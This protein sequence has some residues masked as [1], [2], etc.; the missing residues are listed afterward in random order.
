MLKATTPASRRMM[1]ASSSTPRGRADKASSPRFEFQMLLRCA[2]RPAARA[3]ASG[4]Q[5]RVYVRSAPSGIPTHAPA[6]PSGRPRG[7][8]VR[9][10]GAGVPTAELTDGTLAATSGCTSARPRSPGA[11]ANRTPWDVRRRCPDAEG[12]TVRRC[13]SCAGLTRV[14]VRRTPRDGLPLPGHTRRRPCPLLALTCRTS[15]SSSTRVSRAGKRRG[16]RGRV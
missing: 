8:L 15:S 10:H 11:T 13:C 6:P 9:Q 2:R 7:V 14:I 1:R 12:A 3:A 5:V 4:I 16:G